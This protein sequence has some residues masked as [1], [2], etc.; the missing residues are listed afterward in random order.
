[1]PKHICGE[2]SCA[3]DTKVCPSCGE[4]KLFLEFHRSASKSNGHVSKCKSCVR[5]S[6]ATYNAANRDSHRVRDKQYYLDNQERIK[7]RQRGY[8]AANRDE[9]NCKRRDAYPSAAED[10]RAAS[11]R[12]YEANRE[13]ANERSRRDYLDNRDRYMR[14]ARERYS[15]N[16]D[17]ILAK[18]K[19]YRAEKW[20]T[21]L[22]FRS[23]YYAGNLKRK[24][25]LEGAKQ[26]PYVREDVFA[27]DEWLCHLCGERI[28]PECKF[29]DS[30]SVSIDHVI[31]L[32]L[33]G[34]DTL[35][36]VKAAHLGCNVGKGNRVAPEQ[37]TR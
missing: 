21:D 14:S 30:G 26:E 7:E 4:S 31:P 35:E 1:M 16:R 3:T 9:I 27:R 11:K 12:W 32:S 8:Y 17:E 20:S 29:P 13:Y 23:M 28:D 18:R 22:E 10:Q 6:T 5:I 36:N 2:A 37:A 24:R 33:G 34:D 19:E 15:A 25:L